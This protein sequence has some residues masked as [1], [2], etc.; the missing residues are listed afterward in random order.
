M[1]GDFI[2]KFITGVFEFAGEL[3]ESLSR[4]PY[5]GFRYSNFNIYGYS[6]RKTYSGFKN[7][8]H[9]NLIKRTGRDSF[10]FTKKGKFWFQTINF[11]YFRKKY[12]KWDKKWRLV[13]FDIP[14]T[15][16]NKRDTLRH[17]LKYMG[18]SMLQKS[19]FVFP[20]PCEEEISDICAKLKISNYVDIIIAESIGS[21]EEEFIN[22]FRI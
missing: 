11:K 12:A 3:S 9:R 17:R 16:N 14:R 7:L 5:K 18:F 21:R 8:E 15:L 22:F 19:V 1:K 6:S 13:I 2:I 20:Y 10:K 4:V